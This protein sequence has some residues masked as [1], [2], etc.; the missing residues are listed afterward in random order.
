MKK[1]LRHLLTLGTAAIV[2]A[3]YIFVL[4]SERARERSRACQGL[5]VA[6]VDSSRLSFV[7]EKD[8]A[9]YMEEYGPYVGQL[10]GDV[11]LPRI[12]E[13]LSARSAI[14]GSE[15]W[16]DRD[17]FIH[18]EVTQREPAIRFQKGDRG[19]Y[20]DEKG[21]VF[22]L[23]KNYTSRVPIIDG[24]VPLEIGNEFRGKPASGKE[25]AWLDRI[26][27]MVA[28]MQKE[29]WSERISQIT[30]RPD[31]TLVLI[32]AA[33]TEKFIFGPPTG[34]GAKF[35]RIKTYYEAIVPSL[36]KTVYTSVDIRYDK[37][38]ICKK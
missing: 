23:Q 34:F 24:A 16:L 1:A 30:V 10:L 35:G 28:Y 20:A 25:Q 5:K 8:I 33:G 27:G 14:L 22:P 21:F 4:T 6:I 26:I 29:G 2:A 38:I 9:V 32:P 36:D 17:G 13:I 15:C 31:G 12:E 19:F 11:D 7:S 37:Q 18:I 3:L